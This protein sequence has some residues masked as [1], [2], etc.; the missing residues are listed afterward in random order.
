MAINLQSSPRCCRDLAEQQ[1]FL[2]DSCGPQVRGITRWWRFLLTRF[3]CWPRVLVL[4]TTG[5]RHQDQ[6]SWCRPVYLLQS[7]LPRGF[8]A[9]GS[10]LLTYSTPPK[11]SPYDCALSDYER[12]PHLD[13][14]IIPDRRDCWTEWLYTGTYQ[15]S[16]PLCLPDCRLS[17]WP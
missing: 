15:S 7:T 8:H 1:P 17:S 12:G 5:R 13:S 4:S 6:Q 11:Q 2:P 16:W 14:R 10:Y 3:P 9:Y